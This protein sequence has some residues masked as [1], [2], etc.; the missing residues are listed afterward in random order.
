MSVHQGQWRSSRASVCCRVLLLYW[1]WRRPEAGWSD[2]TRPGPE[3]CGRDVPELG[4]NGPGRR[5]HL[6]EDAELLPQLRCHMFSSGLHLAGYRLLHICSRDTSELGIS[7]DPPETLFSGSLGVCAALKV[8]GLASWL[9][10]QLRVAS[11][12]ATGAVERSEAW[13]VQRRVNCRV[14]PWEKLSN[15]GKH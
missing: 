9:V 13:L 10:S 3:R 15:G 4:A 14:G 2:R 11:G 12:L 1:N 6:V 5:T 7:P 8:L